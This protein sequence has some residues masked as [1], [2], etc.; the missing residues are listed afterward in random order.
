MDLGNYNQWLLPSQKADTVCLLLELGNT[1][2]GV[3]FCQSIN[4][5]SSQTYGYTYQFTGN[6]M[7]E[8]HVKYCHRVGN[9]Q[10]PECEKYYR[11]AQM[12][13][14]FTNKL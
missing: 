6:T 8:G 14:F 2:N 1:F 9:Q 5:K 7:V 12:N 4:P 10:N 11:T 3:F 13:Y